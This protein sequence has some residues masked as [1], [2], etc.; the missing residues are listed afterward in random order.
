MRLAFVAVTRRTWLTLAAA[1]AFGACEDPI[2]PPPS[3]DAAMVDLGV[4]GGLDLGP[5][6]PADLGPCPEQVPAGPYGTEVGD[7]LEPFRFDDCEGSARDLYGL[8]HCDGRVTVVNFAAGWC[9]PCYEE[10]AELQTEIVERYGESVRVVQILFEDARFGEVEPSECRDWVERFGTVG[11]ETLM[12]TTTEATPYLVRSSV[13]TTFVI[14]GDGRIRL[15]LDGTE[16]GLPNV[17]AAIDAI[18]AE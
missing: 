7:A 14:D 8:E 10:T 2:P 6:A 11:I 9:V 15:A 16:S 13:P 1:I 3:V 18:L 4:D 17:R 12:T 5:P